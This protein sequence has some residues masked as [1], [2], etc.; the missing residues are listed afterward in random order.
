MYHV[1]NSSGRRSNVD[2]RLTHHVG[3]DL[4]E[5]VV[6]YLEG[7]DA[8][9]HDLYDVVH[10]RA[11]IVHESFAVHCNFFWLER[12]WLVKSLCSGIGLAGNIND[13]CFVFSFAAAIA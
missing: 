3:E 2:K 11:L 6:E 7:L 4:Q 1:S 8:C 10:S 12:Q 13:T 9:V 5:V